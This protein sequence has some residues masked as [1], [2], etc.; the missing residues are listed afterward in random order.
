MD[1]T[2]I[3]VVVIVVTILASHF[4]SHSQFHRELRRATER[5]HF[6]HGARRAPGRC[7]NSLHKQYSSCCNRT[8][9]WAGHSRSNQ[10]TTRLATARKGLENGEAKQS[11]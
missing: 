10:R 7:P 9:V 6:A 4:V 1:N 8:S 3:G 5:S 2:W 11:E